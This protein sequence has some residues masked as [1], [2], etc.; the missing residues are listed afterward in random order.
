VRSHKPRGTG[1]FNDVGGGGKRAFDCSCRRPIRAN[2]T[3]GGP[4]LFSS[5]C[6]RRRRRRR[7]GPNWPFVDEDDLDSTN[8][9][10]FL[11]LQSP[12][13]HPQIVAFYYTSITPTE[14]SLLE[15]PMLL[16]KNKLQDILIFIFNNANKA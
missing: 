6:C 16:N 7:L 8:R 10:F 1:G 13:C 15:H 3:R 4:A 14:K 2:P 9:S 5:C 11:F 12:S